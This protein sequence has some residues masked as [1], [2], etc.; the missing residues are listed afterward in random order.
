MAA[1]NTL[2]D[3]L[4][5]IFVKK[6]PKLPA[7]AKKVIVQYL[8]WINVILGVLTIWAAWA[9]WQWAHVADT[10]IDYANNIS[11]IYGGGDVVTS[12]MSLSIWL[13]VI[14]LAIEA[15]LYLAAFPGTRDRKKIGW[16]LLF[17]AAL[18]NVVYAVLVLFTDYGGFGNLLGGLIGSAIGLWLL[19]QIRDSYKDSTATSKANK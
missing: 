7:N 10:L 16:N 13:G 15:L 9:L 5:D 11:R 3:A 4:A 17:Y 1:T 18:V 8:P 12:R 14:V 19:F 2:E 6:A